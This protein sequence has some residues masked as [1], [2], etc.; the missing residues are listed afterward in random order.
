MCTGGSSRKEFLKI[1]GAGLAGATLLGVAGCGG[2][3]DQGKV[4]RMFVGTATAAQ[5][6]E[7]IRLV[8][9]FDEENPKYTVERE[10]IPPDQVREVIQTRLRSEQPPDYFGYD[11]GP[12]FAGVLAEAG[13]L[14][15]LDKAYKENGW[16]DWAS[17]RFRRQAYSIPSQVEELIYYNK[18]LVPEVPKTSTFGRWR[19]T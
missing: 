15:P 17:S 7:A 16:T 4:I 8:E 3:S 1:G 5:E 2:S 10:S 14:Y 9:R 18:D 6:R 11:T 13:L 19:T 12:G